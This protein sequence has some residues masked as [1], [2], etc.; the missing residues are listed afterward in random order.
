MEAEKLIFW[1]YEIGMEYNDA[2]GKKCASL[3][4]MT[5]MGLPVPPGFALSI[6]VYD[7]FLKETGVGEKISCYIK[8]LGDLEGKGIADFQEISRDICN[9]ILSQ[10]I[11]ERIE[12]EIVSHYEELCKEVDI[13]D[14]PVAVRSAGTA[15]RPG[16]FET[17]LN[18]KGKEEVL[19]KIKS[20]W[21]SAFTPRA[22]AFR[23]NKG[24]PLDEDKLGVAVI[25][26]VKARSAGVGFTAHPI[27]GDDTKILLEAS[28]GLGES[29][30][31]GLV[32]PDRF[33]IDKEGTELIEKK[34]G[35]KDKLLE[36]AEQG[37]VEQDVTME[38]RKLPCI[39]DEEAMK[40][41]DY[42]GI[43]ESHYGMPQD[44]EWVIDQDMM[45][46]NNIFFVQTRPIKNLPKMK[47]GEDEDYLV[48]LMVQMV[49]Q[50][51]SDAKNK[52]L[53]EPGE[54]DTD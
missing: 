9:M 20:V 13:N 21:A 35:E 45:F 22:I 4:E 11:P 53:A 36:F 38:K 27:T 2:V 1:F 47:K 28:W 51:S 23:V 49:E 5:R 52:S 31:Q 24:I 40:L 48:D 29:I 42:A 8:E 17:H 15:S 12:L 26:M 37:I 18:I 33:T 44:F 25:K 43:L 34:I 19:D 39:S 6:N 50:L 16:M 30:V 46:P 41:A 14:V 32:N 54:N 7:E 3:G 10:S